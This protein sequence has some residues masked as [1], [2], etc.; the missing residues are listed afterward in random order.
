VPVIFFAE[1]GPDGSLSLQ[2]YDHTAVFDGFVRKAAVGQEG[3]VPWNSNGR[4]GS[5]PQ[6]L[7]YRLAEIKKMN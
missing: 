4:A 3:S 5:G 2:D 7:T 6:T 1:A